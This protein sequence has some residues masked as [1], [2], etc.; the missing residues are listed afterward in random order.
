MSWAGLWGSP[1]RAGWGGGNPQPHACR[2]DPSG[3]SVPGTGSCSVP[4]EPLRSAFAV[5]LGVKPFRAA[6]LQEMGTNEAWMQVG[7]SWGICWYKS[8]SAF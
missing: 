2:A 5:Y 1:S 7:V 8:L 6:L 3:G 4:A